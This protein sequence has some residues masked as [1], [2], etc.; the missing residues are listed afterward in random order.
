MG[1]H[2]SDFVQNCGEPTSDGRARLQEYVSEF[3]SRVRRRLLG[4]MRAISD[5]F[6]DLEDIL[7]SARRRMDQTFH[8]GRVQFRSSA[9]VEAYF[10]R[11]AQRVAI[12]A[13]RRRNIERSSLRRVAEQHP[14]Q[15]L[16]DRINDEFDLRQLD[17]EAWSIILRR[18]NGQSIID[19]AEADG[20]DV[21]ALRSRWR[22]LRQRLQLAAGRSRV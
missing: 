1:H 13:A 4:K 17:E 8:A 21:E 10:T 15:Q 12:D 2:S 7:A 11:I 18:R 9:E 16:Q 14:A 22:R 19:I 3:E 20:L 6:H 5:N